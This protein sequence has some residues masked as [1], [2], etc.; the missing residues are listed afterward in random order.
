MHGQRTLNPRFA[1]LGFASLAIAIA[2]PLWAFFKVTVPFPPMLA[3][4]HGVTAVNTP[5][6][7]NLVANDADADG[8]ID[9]KSVT[10]L[11]QPEHGIATV[12]PQTGVCTYAPGVGF[13]GNDKFS[14]QLQDDEGIKSNVGF[15]AVTVEPPAEE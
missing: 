1:I 8:R 4:D 14:Y 13:A 12:N 6:D 11:T 10:L 7:I 3:D 2:A 9:L 15:V 5:V